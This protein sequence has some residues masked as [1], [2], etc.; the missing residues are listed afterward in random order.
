MI[1]HGLVLILLWLTLTLSGCGLVQML[2]PPPPPTPAERLAEM[3]QTM[4]LLQAMQQQ[5]TGPDPA[6]EREIQ[7]LHQSIREIVGILRDLHGKSVE[8]DYRLKQLEGR[9]K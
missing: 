7:S 1:R 5:K 4:V 6:I 8:H 3:Q 9:P 2:R